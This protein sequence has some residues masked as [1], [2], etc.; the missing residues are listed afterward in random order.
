MRKLFETLLS[1]PSMETDPLTQANSLYYADTPVKNGW[2]LFGFSLRHQPRR[3]I[4][5]QE[6]TNP[7]GN[8]PLRNQRVVQRKKREAKQPP[9]DFFLGGFGLLE[10]RRARCRTSSTPWCPRGRAISS[11]SQQTPPSHC[12]SATPRRRCS[13]WGTSA[14]RLLNR[15]DGSGGKRVQP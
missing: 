9:S 5:Q 4:S 14:R 2:L 7:S 11:P 15:S 1:L 8:L 12:R 3:F 6:H 10:S 13:H